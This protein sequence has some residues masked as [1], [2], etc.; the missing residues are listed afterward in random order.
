MSQKTQF[1]MV[2]CMNLSIGF[3]DLHSIFGASTEMSH[4]MQLSMVICSPKRLPFELIFYLDHD[5]LW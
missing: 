5:P 1:S 4:K 3:G 2:I